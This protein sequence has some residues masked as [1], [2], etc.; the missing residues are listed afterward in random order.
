LYAGGDFTTAGGKVSAYA[1]GAIIDPGNWLSI[2]ANVPGPRTNTLTYVGI[3]S[4][5]YVTQYATNLSGSPWFALVTNSPGTYGIGT[6]RD[7]AATD[8]QRFYRLSGP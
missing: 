4:T 5:N 7:P 3:P 6:V 8:Q 1:A 2:Q